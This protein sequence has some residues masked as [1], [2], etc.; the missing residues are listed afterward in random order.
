[1]ALGEIGALD[2]YRV[3]QLQLD[4]QRSEAAASIAVGAAVSRLN[5]AQG[6]A[7]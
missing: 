7:P 4:A 6:Y 1:M 2:F 5:Q 3:R